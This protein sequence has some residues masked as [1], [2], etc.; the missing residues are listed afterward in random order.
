MLGYCKIMGSCFILSSAGQKYFDLY[1]AGRETRRK[2]GECEEGRKEE[3]EEDRDQRAHG[4]E[5]RS[6]VWLGP[7]LPDP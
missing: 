1:L 2:G 7:A 5:K 3:E 4:R 6:E